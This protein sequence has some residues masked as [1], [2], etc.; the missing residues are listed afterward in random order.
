MA[1][2]EEQVGYASLLERFEES[3]GELYKEYARLF[4]HHKR[5]WQGLADDEI[6]HADW[7]RT[8]RAR[9]EDGSVR[10]SQEHVISPDHVLNALDGVA[11][12]LARAKEGR[13]LP[14][15]GLAAALSLEREMI[16]NEWFRFFETDADL[17]KRVLQSLGN[18]T[19]RHADSL[20]R[21]W[22]DDVNRPQSG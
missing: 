19:R 22:D 14:V 7:V 8:L 11:R 16:E 5:V 3:I 15:D 13:V 10:F 6:Q 4:P 1:S 12:L 21:L 20:Q 17:I 2:Q 9:I 18:D